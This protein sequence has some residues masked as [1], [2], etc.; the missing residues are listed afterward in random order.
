MR[1]AFLGFKILFASA[2]RAKNP[3][4]TDNAVERDNPVQAA[5]PNRTGRD[6][7]W[8]FKFTGYIPRHKTTPNLNIL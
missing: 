4:E 2:F 3:L 8:R 5:G 1:S 7:T 6:P